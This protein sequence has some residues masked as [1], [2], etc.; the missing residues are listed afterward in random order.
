MSFLQFLKARQAH[1]LPSTLLATRNIFNDCLQE[2]DIAT[3]DAERLAELKAKLE[4][5]PDFTAV[6]ADYGR[7]CDD[8]ENARVIYDTARDAYEVAERKYLYWKNRQ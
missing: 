3:T 5:K 8:Y 4:V 7:A 1:R 6:Q 2:R